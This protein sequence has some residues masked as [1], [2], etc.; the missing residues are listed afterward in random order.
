MMQIPQDLPL[1]QVQEYE[2]QLLNQTQ[3]SAMHRL[4]STR[5]HDNN[6]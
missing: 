2:E 3:V 5:S 1:S 4:P 6:I